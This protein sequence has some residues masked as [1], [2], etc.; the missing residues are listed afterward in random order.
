M[1]IS[2]LWTWIIKTSKPFIEV[3]ETDE[4]SQETDDIRRISEEEEHEEITSDQSSESDNSD[5]VDEELEIRIEEQNG[6]INNDE[7]PVV[8]N[9]IERQ[10][11]K[12]M[13]KGKEMNK[14]A[15]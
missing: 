12:K 8:I 15:Q 4:N 3:E 1:M 5:N 9:D 14:R 6:G 2:R 7:T 10:L 11:W 13:G